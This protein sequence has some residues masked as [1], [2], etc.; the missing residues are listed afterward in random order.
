MRFGNLIA[1]GVREAVDTQGL[2]GV[3]SGPLCAAAAGI[4]AALIF[5]FI[6]SLIFKGKRK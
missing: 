3:L 6:A 4:S 2:L 5:G 1:Q